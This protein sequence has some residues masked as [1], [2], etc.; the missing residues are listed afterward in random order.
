MLL[1]WAVLYDCDLGDSKNCYWLKLNCDVFVQV[2]II[3]TVGPQ[4]LYF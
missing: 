1:N 4:L 2:Y 3:F